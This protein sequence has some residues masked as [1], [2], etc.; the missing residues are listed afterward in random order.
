MVELLD[1]LAL[2]SVIGYVFT[3]YFFRFEPRVGFLISVVPLLATSIMV[4]IGQDYYA[5]VAGTI[6][7]SLLASS[8]GH[9]VLAAWRGR[10]QNLDQKNQLE[11]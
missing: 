4:A 6:T 10:S 9:A 5:T 3:A 2:S 8:V 1:L 7:L 11:F